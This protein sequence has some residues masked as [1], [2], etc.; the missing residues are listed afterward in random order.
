MHRNRLVALTAQLALNNLFSYAGF[1]KQ[2]IPP[3]AHS[4]TAGA[5]PVET[6]ESIMGTWLE[7][8]G[9]M[10]I[11]WLSRLRRQANMAQLHDVSLVTG[12]LV[13]KHALMYPAALQGALEKGHL[14]WAHLQQDFFPYR[15]RAF[16]CSEIT[17]QTIN[18]WNNPTK[19]D[20]KYGTLNFLQYT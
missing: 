4:C 17:I 8:Y 16:Y 5:R 18:N 3:A 12:K 19:S 10:S 9:R 6:T 1:P 7:R 20:S 11:A 15:K 13:S 14:Q 2:L